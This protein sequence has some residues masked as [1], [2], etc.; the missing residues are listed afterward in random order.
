MNWVLSLSGYHLM[1]LKTEADLRKFMDSR[2]DGGYIYVRDTSINDTN[3]PHFKSFTKDFYEEKVHTSFAMASTDELRNFLKLP[4]KGS[5]LVYIGDANL[6][7]RNVYNGKYE[8]FSD[9]SDFYEISLIRD[10]DELDKSLY[11]ERK[12]NS[13]AFTYLFV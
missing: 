12:F 1:Q 11:S 10:F 5:H 2:P 3:F 9:I 6:N 4:A 8:E 13:E 7:Y